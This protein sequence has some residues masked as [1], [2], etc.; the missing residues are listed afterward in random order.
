[1]DGATAMSVTVTAPGYT[2]TPNYGYLK[3]ISLEDDDLWGDHINLNWDSLDTKLYQVETR[4]ANYLPLIGGTMQGGI[5]FG[6]AVGAS[7]SDVTRHLPLYGGTVGLG[8]STG[9]RFNFVTPAGFSQFFVCSGIDVAQFNGGGLAV[10]GNLTVGV[11]GGSPSLYL[12][13]NTAPASNLYM[14]SLAG[15]NSRNIFIQTGGS[16]RW[17]VRAVNVESGSNNGTNFDIARFDD[18]GTNLGS[19]LTITRSN[20]AVAIPGPLTVTNNVNVGTSGVVTLT[21]NGNAGASSTFAINGAGG[22]NKAIQFQT[23]GV[24][25]WNAFIAGAEGGSNAGADFQLNRYAD[26]GTGMGAVLSFTRSTGLGTVFGDPT[27][28]L[29]IA[30]KQYVDN[31]APV[32]G[33]YLQLLGGHVTGSLTVDGPAAFGATVTV[34]SR[35]QTNDMMNI[36]GAYYVGGSTSYY[37]ARNGTD[38]TWSWVEN[39]VANMTLTST[40]NLGLKGTLTVAGAATVGDL[41]SNGALRLGNVGAYFS[42]DGSY[43]YLAFDSGGW[44]WQYYRSTGQINYI[45]G[46]DGA[47]LFLLDPN[48]NGS[49]PG[50]WMAAAGNYPDNTGNWRFYMSSGY[51]FQQFTPGWNWN[52][53]I[54]N[55]QLIYSIPGGTQ[56]HYSVSDYVSYNWLAGQA[57]NGAYINASDERI[58]A[59]IAEA[60][61]GLDEILAIK[62]ITFRR[63][64]QVK[65]TYHDRTELGF[66]ARQIQAVLPEAVI[67]TDTPDD[68]KASI[69]GGDPVLAIQSEAIVAALVNAVKTLN[70]R[71]AALE[72]R[73]IH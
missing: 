26:A 27:A 33:P 32:G 50:S 9:A 19:A 29:G 1:M 42:S 62:P 38:G 24:L 44:R 41:T 69:A 15:S 21:L 70:T 55:G 36:A 47:S 35:L 40:G 51:R 20:G 25:R 57:G 71:L 31:K 4:Q 64:H 17:V 65:K 30:T 61:H 48:G 22:Q 49:V 10:F 68:W 2:T 60:P 34:A 5:S 43:T 53:N 67:A 13:N 66:G 6:S 52:W 12:G 45:R 56:Y 14:N 58:K 23:A 16:T 8:I 28:A 7:P 37:F 54:S 59:D 18:S 73:T 72:E 46:N 39:N 11:A 63:W 3:P